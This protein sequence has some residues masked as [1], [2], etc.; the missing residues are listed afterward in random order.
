M[1]GVL[2]FTAAAQGGAYC[3]LGSHGAVTIKETVLGGLPPPGNCTDSR[4]K[5]TPFFL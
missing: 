4:L 5:H 3:V 2:V 1:S